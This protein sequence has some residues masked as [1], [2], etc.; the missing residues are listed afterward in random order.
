METLLELIK[1]QQP[2]TPVCLMSTIAYGSPYYNKLGGVRK[3]RDEWLLKRG[4][5]I[6]EL[7]TYLYYLLGT[8]LAHK[9]KSST[10]ARKILLVL[11][12]KPLC[13]IFSRKTS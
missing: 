7:L 9:I 1:A 12:I 13:Y 6:G 8:P 11:I 10:K 3:F 2:Y 5:K 4:G